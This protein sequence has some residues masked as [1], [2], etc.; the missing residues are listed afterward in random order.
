MSTIY[1]EPY[2]LNVAAM[3]DKLRDKCEDLIRSKMPNIEQMVAGLRYSIEICYSELRDDD[4]LGP[5]LTSDPTRLLSF[6]DGSLKNI[7]VGKD[8]RYS[9]RDIF[10]VRV[11][12]EEDHAISVSE[13]VALGSNKFVYV[14]GVVLTSYQSNWHNRFTYVCP[15]GH[16]TDTRNKLGNKNRACSNF[17]CGHEISA[18]SYLHVD[19][20]AIIIVEPDYAIPG[21]GSSCPLDC[22]IV[23]EIAGTVKPGDYVRLGGIVQIDITKNSINKVLYVNSIT[24]VDQVAVPMQRDDLDKFPADDVLVDRLIDRL[25]PRI[26]GQHDVI[27]AILYMLAGARDYDN[28]QINSSDDERGA[29]HILLVGDLY[30]LETAILK[31]AYKVAPKGYYQ[32]TYSSH[33]THLVADVIRDKGSNAVE[34]GAM[35]MGDLGV[36]CLDQIHSLSKNYVKALAETMERQIVTIARRGLH[37]T[38]NARVSVLAAFETGSHNVRARPLTDN[39]NLPSML[40][41]QFD[42]VF[43]LQ[44]TLYGERLHGAGGEQDAA[45]NEQIQNAIELKRYIQHVKTI[46]PTVPDP[47]RDRLNRWYKQWRYTDQ[48]IYR[49]IG[50]CMRRQNTLL[51]LAIAR[52]RLYRRN[53]VTMNDADRTIQLFQAMIEMW[54][55]TQ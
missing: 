40:L 5:I 22:K 3:G 36:V 28:Q 33:Y 27:E 53:E 46:N 23:G 34:A 10:T 43:P 35:V 12:A 31:A 9:T 51:R 25:E 2:D 24:R 41:E 8:E 17:V 6:L 47:I 37:S 39:S 15:D 52:A 50:I 14:T 48:A 54:S 1:K 11:V 29:I 49:H 55:N 4:T 13:A 42:L 20:Q 45:D 18:A 19:T 32:T 38:L 26:N 30:D 21:T 16:L 7:A 44:N